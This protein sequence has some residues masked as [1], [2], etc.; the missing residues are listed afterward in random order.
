MAIPLNFVDPL[1]LHW[2][3]WA[4]FNEQAWQTAADIAAGFG[5]GLTGGLTKLIRQGLG[6][7]S[8]VDHC[9]WGYVGGV[10]GG[11]VYQFVLLSQLGAEGGCFVQARRS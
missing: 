11:Q 2:Y 1:G 10:V 9:S 8:Q 6:V 7:D 5:D 4:I 3:D